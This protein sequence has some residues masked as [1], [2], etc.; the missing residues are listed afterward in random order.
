VI[1]DDVIKRYRVEHVA[2]LEKLL[3]F[4]LASPGQIISFATLAKRLAASTGNVKVDT[5]IRY[6]EYLRS[7]YAVFDLGRFDW[8]LSRLFE[9]TRKYY[10]VDTGIMGLFRSAAENRSFLLENLVYLELRRRGQIPHFGALPQGGELDFLAP[11]KGRSWQ[12]IQVCTRVTD[13]NRQRE[14]SIFASVQPRLQQSESLLLVESGLPETID[15]GGV[16][17]RQRPMVRWLLEV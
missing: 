15:L 2:I 6:V 9:T 11:L 7:V 13:D 16:V 8:K 3:A 17:V 10:G 5:V 4:I 1:L 12:A 14:L